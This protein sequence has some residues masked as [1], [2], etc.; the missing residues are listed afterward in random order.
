ME[1][2]LKKKK[3]RKIIANRYERNITCSYCFIGP[4]DKIIGTYFMNTNNNIQFNSIKKYFNFSVRR[5]IRV[6]AL[7]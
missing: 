1:K 5:N 4:V 3:K 2:D 6:N 7:L